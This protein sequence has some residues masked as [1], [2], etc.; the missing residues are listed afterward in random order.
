MR[1]SISI[2][3]LVLKEMQPVNS[4]ANFLPRRM[5][6]ASMT[7]I[8]KIDPG[9][10]LKASQ[11]S[12]ENDTSFD[13]TLLEGFLKYY[14]IDDGQRNILSF[15]LEEFKPLGCTAEESLVEQEDGSKAVFI[16]KIV[17]GG[18]AEKAGLKVGDAIVGVSGNFKDIVNV[19]GINLEKVKSLIGAREE[20]EGLVLK[21]IRGS[22]VMAQ[23]ESTMVQ[24]C[25][26]PENDKDVDK[27]IEA[28]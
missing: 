26:V 9:V 27:C 14:N 5:Y 18:N 25:V 24:L 21:I 1:L 10:S 23:H 11:T 17:E 22:D 13:E 6:D 15:E 19:V 7:T 16:S 28:M 12:E 2:V 3:M 20:A 8:S 4:F